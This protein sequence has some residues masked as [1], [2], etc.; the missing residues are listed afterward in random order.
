VN[1]PLAFDGDLDTWV[2][3]QDWSCGGPV[4][5]NNYGTLPTGADAE[6]VPLFPEY[7]NV[8]QLTFSLYPRKDPWRS[9]AAVDSFAP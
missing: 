6:W 1:N 2:C 7:V 3:H 8:K 4:L 5:P 9:W